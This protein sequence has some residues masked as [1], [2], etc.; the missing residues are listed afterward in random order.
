M[1]NN[2]GEGRKEEIR[3]IALSEKQRDKS[4]YLFISL[5]TSRVFKRKPNVEKV[6]ANGEQYNKYGKR[7]EHTNTHAHYAGLMVGTSSPVQVTGKMSLQTNDGH[8]ETM[9]CRETLAEDIDFRLNG[10]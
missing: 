7:K 2:K 8:I 10:G 1:S 9:L 6:M 4:F 5:A 3:L